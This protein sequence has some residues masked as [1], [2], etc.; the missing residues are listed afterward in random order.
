MANKAIEIIGLL[1]VIAVPL[2]GFLY[3]RRKKLKSYFKFIWKKSSSLKPKQ[4]LELRPY[5]PDYHDRDE[6]S[7]ILRMLSVKENVLILGAPP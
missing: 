6:D 2:T 7:L 3:W 1:L 5:Y 4:L